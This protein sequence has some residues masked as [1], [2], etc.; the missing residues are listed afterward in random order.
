MTSMKQTG[1][2]PFWPLRESAWQRLV[3]WCGEMRQLLPSQPPRR[4]RVRETLAIGDKRQLLIV[5]CGHRQLLIGAAGNF[6]AMLAE[7]PF[8]ENAE[9]ENNARTC[10]ILSGP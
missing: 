6:L 2:T 10:E 8:A 4:M 3:R 7:L 1:R 9:G 5:Q